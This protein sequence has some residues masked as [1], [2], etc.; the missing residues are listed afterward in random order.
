VSVHKRTQHCF[1]GK[2]GQLFVFLTSRLW[3]FLATFS[4]ALKGFAFSGTRFI[5]DRFSQCYTRTPG[6]WPLDAKSVQLGIQSFIG[7]SHPRKFLAKDAHA[8]ANVDF[9]FQF[10]VSAASAYGFEGIAG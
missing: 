9:D 8:V 2:R 4:R 7:E 5:A 10:D 1:G 3:D 6:D